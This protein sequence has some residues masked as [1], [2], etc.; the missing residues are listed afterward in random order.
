MKEF[1][2]YTLADWP[3]RKGGELIFRTSNEAIY[4]ATLVENRLEAIDLLTGWRKK[5]L[6][7][8]SGLKETQGPNYDRLFDLACRAQLYREAMEEIERLG[9]EGP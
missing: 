2:A 5:T 6:E 4:F 3:R 7:D 9:M 8:I 1:H